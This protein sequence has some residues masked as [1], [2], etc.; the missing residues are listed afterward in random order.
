MGA[1]IHVCSLSRLHDT[2]AETGA[3][4]VV[5]LL[6]NQT[7][8]AAL[9]GIDVA[10]HLRLQ[11]DDIADPAENMIVPVD[12]HIDDLLRFV[13]AWDR[14]TPLVVHCWAGISRSTAGAYTTVCALAPHRTELSIAQ[15]LR[16]ASP[17][18]SPNRR[19]IAIADRALGRDGRMVAAIEAIGTGIAADEAVPFRLDIE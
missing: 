11:L 15:A 2:V 19:L 4:H 9:P 16:R 13:R 1:M 10:N 12:Q 7:R 14:S 6:A 5:T 3:R 17:T 8:V 18:A